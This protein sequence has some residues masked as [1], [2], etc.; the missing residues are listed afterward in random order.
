VW[1]SIVRVV[2]H[3][4]TLSARGRNFYTPFQKKNLNK[5]VV[6]DLTERTSICTPPPHHNGHVV[7]L[8]LVLVVVSKKKDSIFF[9]LLLFFLEIV[10]F[11]GRRIKQKRGMRHVHVHSPLEDSHDLHPLGVSATIR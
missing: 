9:V 8:V 5:S 2:L 11:L 10:Y 4:V 3:G 6:H 1:A 7:V